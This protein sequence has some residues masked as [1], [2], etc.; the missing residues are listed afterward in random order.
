MREIKDLIIL[1]LF[2]ASYGTLIA[3]VSV[4]LVGGFKWNFALLLILAVIVLI[5]SFA[6]L[7][8][9]LRRQ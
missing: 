3:T 8:K 6:K 2:I 7:P 9:M 5:Y 1:T 4:L